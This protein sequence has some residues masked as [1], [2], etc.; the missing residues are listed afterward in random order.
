MPRKAQCYNTKILP[1]YHGYAGCIVEGV[2]VLT[3]LLDTKIN[4][5]RYGIRMHIQLQP[6]VIAPLWRFRTNLGTF[7][8]HRSHV[9]GAA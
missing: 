7:W 3:G 1:N 9:A 4:H 5:C 2:S 8:R 6:R